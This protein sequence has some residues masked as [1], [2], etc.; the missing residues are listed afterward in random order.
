MKERAEKLNDLMQR[1]RAAFNGLVLTASCGAGALALG[2]GLVVRGE[3]AIAV[4]VGLWAAA[5]LRWAVAFYQ[6]WQ[7]RSRDVDGCAKELVD[8][9]SSAVTGTVRVLVKPRCWKCGTL[10]SSSWAQREDDL[11]LRCGACL[12]GP[13]VLPGRAEAPPLTG[14]LFVYVCTWCQSGEHHN[15]LGKDSACAC[16]RAGHGAAASAHKVN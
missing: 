14:A 11:S 3:R 5:I 1:E 12:S 6:R 2:V 10:A 13:A 8:V 4:L 16:M 15:C 9:P 7:A